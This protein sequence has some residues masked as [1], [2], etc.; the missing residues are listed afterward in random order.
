ME[1]FADG[2]PAVVA[3]NMEMI[4]QMY[5]S[6]RKEVEC[7]FLLGTFLEQVHKEVML[8]EKE[9]LVNTLKGVLRSRLTQNRSKAVPDVLLPQSCSCPA[10]A[11]L[12]L[13]P[14]W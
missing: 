11:A 14:G 13:G 4:M 12:K 1:L 3:T 5:P 9:L 10:C 7:S 2:G 6:C 8:K